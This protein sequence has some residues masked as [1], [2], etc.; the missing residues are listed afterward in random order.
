MATTSDLQVQIMDICVNAIGRDAVGIDDDL[1]ELGM[2]SVAAVEIVTRIESAYGA[3]VVD[4]IFDSP[5][6]RHLQEAVD[7]QRGG[8]VAHAQ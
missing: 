5:T 4:V 7:A 8:S 6:V 1:I 3:D 2:D